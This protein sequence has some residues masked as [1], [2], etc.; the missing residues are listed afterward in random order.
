MTRSPRCI[1][2]MLAALAVALVGLPGYPD[3]PDLVPLIGKAAPSVVYVLASDSTGQPI[4]S[5]TGFAVGAHGLVLTALHV[6][7]DAD[8]VLV[9]V[10]GQEP[11]GADVV[12]ADT[13]HDVAVLDVPSMPV[14][15]PPPLALGDSSAVRLGQEVVV[16]GYPLA[17]PQH[18]TLA[19]THGIVSAVRKDIGIPH[20]DVGYVQVDAAMNPGVSGGPVLTL[21]GNV[22]G[23]ADASVR[24]AQNVNFAV[25]IDVARP[26][27]QRA[28]SAGPLP[29][30][31]PLPLT[32]P[33]QVALTYS[34]KG[35]GP[36]SR[37]DRQG[38][39]CVAPPP[40]AAEIDQV[41]VALTSGSSL[42]VVTWLSWDEGAPVNSPAS[43]ARL[44]AT[45][46]HSLHGVLPNLHLQPGTVC[47]NYSASNDSVF[48][49]GETFHVEYML[50][51]RVF[52]I[53]A[54]P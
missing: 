18:P 14:P 22:I 5:G 23:I 33:A 7:Q 16:L 38:A 32:S 13:R 2:G 10:P 17:P 15:G 29:T 12:T 42:K 8:R 20:T 21:D 44:D 27:V 53:P 54:T 35:I 28:A 49:I 41:Q 3:T 9:V 36:R 6:V 34:S 19:V 48:P 39:S 26:L 11:L 37:Q 46:S 40:A 51:Y 47:L 25:P 24:G 31:L 4:E 43:F 52:H 45:S 1:A 50:G 30:P